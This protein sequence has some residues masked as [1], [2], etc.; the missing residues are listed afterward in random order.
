MREASLAIG[1]NAAYMHQFLERGM[2]RR[3]QLSGQRDAGRAARMR[4]G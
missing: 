2:P 1:R 3:A 4:R